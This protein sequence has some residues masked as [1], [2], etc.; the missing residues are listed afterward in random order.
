MCFSDCDSSL[1]FCV[2]VCGSRAPMFPR[3]LGVRCETDFNQL[4]YSIVW[5]SLNTQAHIH[6]NAHK[7]THTHAD[8]E[9]PCRVQISHCFFS[10]NYGNLSSQREQPSQTGD[11]IGETPPVLLLIGFVCVLLL[12]NQSCPV[13]KNDTFN[14][15]VTIYFPSKCD[16]ATAL[17]QMMYGGAESR[18]KV[19][20]SSDLIFELVINI[21]SLYK[22]AG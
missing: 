10:D 13:K 21:S 18:Y 17:S 16:I 22:I 8:T 20:L 11:V 1:L 5:L 12:M 19:V 9:P 4:C 15:A 7:Q 2:C 6:T 3:A 14:L